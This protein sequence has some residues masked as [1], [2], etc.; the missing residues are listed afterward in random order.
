MRDARRRTISSRIRSPAIL[1]AAVRRLLFAALREISGAREELSRKDGQRH[2]ADF[3]SCLQATARDQNDNSSMVFGDASGGW[4][5]ICDVSLAAPRVFRSPADLGIGWEAAVNLLD[6]SRVQGGLVH[7]L[8]ERAGRARSWSEDA[9]SNAGVG[10]TPRGV[11]KITQT[12]SDTDIRVC[13]FFYRSFYYR[14]VA[15]MSPPA[16]NLMTRI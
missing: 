16:V 3:C 1:D 4:R 14:R 5:R 15:S 13:R 10:R 9:F 12:A 11:A 7:Y 8:R 6:S 2:Y